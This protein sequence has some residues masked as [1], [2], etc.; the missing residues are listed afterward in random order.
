MAMV[1]NETWICKTVGTPFSLFGR[2]R[3]QDTKQF[4]RFS[5]WKTTDDMTKRLLFLR[6]LAG[7][8]DGS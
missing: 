2:K 6:L 1:N 4:A 7:Q 8:I 5:L 3:L